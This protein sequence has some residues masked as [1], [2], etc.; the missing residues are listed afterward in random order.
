MHIYIFFSY[1]TGISFNF[2]VHGENTVCTSVNIQRQ[3]TLFRLSRRH[4]DRGKRQP[5][6]LGPWSLRAHLLPDQ[7]R[8]VTMPVPASHPAFA[9]DGLLH[10]SIPPCIISGLKSFAAKVFPPKIFYIKVHPFMGMT[11]KAYPETHVHTAYVSRFLF[12]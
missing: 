1:I 10:L 3:P 5:V 4:L 7:P 2:F 11:W 8:I 6:I 9:N 12:F